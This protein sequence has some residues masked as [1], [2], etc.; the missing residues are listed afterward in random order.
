MQIDAM[1]N[2]QSGGV[3]RSLIFPVIGEFYGLDTAGIAS[4]AQGTFHPIWVD[5][6]TG[7]LQVWTAPV[8]VAGKA[9]RNGSEDLAVLTDITQSVALS[10]SN[11]NYDDKTGSLSLDARLTNTSKT[12][13]KSPL[14]VRVIGLR[15]G[16]GTVRITNADNGQTA[17][18]AVW[19][20]TRLIEGGVLGPGEKTQTKRF[21]FSLKDIR[22]F[23]ANQFGRR[24]SELVNLE[25]KVLGTSDK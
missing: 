10:F 7:V 5:N 15:T 2:F 11:T 12:L 16:S 8:I 23:S 18:G 20:F 13:L 3:I 21:E 19:D 4:D 14:K 1:R 6:R 17:T 25:T 22:P 9:V 24:P